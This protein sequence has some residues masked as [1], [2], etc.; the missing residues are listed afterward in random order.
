MSVLADLEEYLRYMGQIGYSGLA[1]EHNPFEPPAP[2]PPRARTPAP[3][4]T[5]AGPRAVPPPAG[6][7][8]P[9]PPPGKAARPK[10]VNKPQIPN[11]ASIMSMITAAAPVEDTRKMAASV[12]GDNGMDLLRGL[13]KTF[14]TCQACALGTTRRQFV[15]G[16][17]PP[18]SSI[19]FVGD[20]P[21]PH[22]NQSGRPFSDDAGQLLTKIIQG[23]KLERKAVFITNVVKCRPP[24][25]NPLPDEIN[26]CAPLLE[27]QIEAVK[28]RVIVALGSTALRFFIGPNVSIMRSRGA[29]VEWR[30][31]PVMPTFHPSYILRNPRSKREVWEDLKKVMARLSAS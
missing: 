16:E 8:P 29:F 10:Q 13:Y 22:D 12:E 27:R 18:E 6:L 2:A 15:F 14:S 21:S 11:V 1:L 5:P 3:H 20:G 25:R 28:P 24:D 31:I 7:Q 17:G 30:G 4:A 19:M 26:S 9:A 23:M